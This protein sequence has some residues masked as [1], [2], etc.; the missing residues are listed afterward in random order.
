MTRL[1][2]T[3]HQKIPIDALGYITLGLRA[4][5]AA[6]NRPLVGYSSLAAGADQLFAVEL[7]KARGVLHAV[8]PSNGYEST[9][10]PDDLVTYRRLLAAAADTTH[11]PF[12][13]PDEDAYDA[14]GKWIVEHSDVLVAVWDGKEARGLGGTADAVAHAR[15]FGRDVQIVWPVGTIRG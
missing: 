14:A 8:V 9:F 4:I 1:G 2:I 5:L 12:P 11:L 6:Q 3:G 7:L 15:K 13:A 10:S